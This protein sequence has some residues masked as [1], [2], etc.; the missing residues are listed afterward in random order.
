MH[1]IV[2]NKD[3]IM[4]AC[5]KIASQEGL[6]AVNM[7]SVAKE[8]GIALGTLYNYYEDKD[9]LLLAAV[10]SVWMDIFHMDHREFEHMSFIECVSALFDSAHKGSLQYPGFVSAHS[11][12]I[13]GTKKTEARTEMDHV[14]THMKEGLLSVLSQDVDINQT[15]FSPSF[16][17][18][19]F[20]DIVLDQLVLLL[21]KNEDGCHTLIELIRRV[22]YR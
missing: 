22:I 12:L 16:T 1:P 8:C 13:A 4:Q 14:F 2:T 20:I 5:R 9:A 6:S 17:E 3:E 19:D 21:T 11:L 7:R 18:E 15:V 10:H